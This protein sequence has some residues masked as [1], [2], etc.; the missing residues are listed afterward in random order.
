MIPQNRNTSQKQAIRQMFS[1]HNRP[2]SIEEVHYGAQ[3]HATGLS[4]A[5]V[6]RNINAFLDDGW[7]VRISMP[8]LPTRYELSGKGHHHHFHCTTCQKTFDLPGCGLADDAGL[9]TGFKAHAHEHFVYGLCAG[10]NA[11]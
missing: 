5:T 6:Y 1:Q 2:L 9:P 3:A 11:A 10:C 4:L 8:G 7:L